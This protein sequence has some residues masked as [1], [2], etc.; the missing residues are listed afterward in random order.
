MP[1]HTVP[2]TGVPPVTGA[3]QVVWRAAGEELPLAVMKTSARRAGEAA[4]D[5]ALARLDRTGSEELAKEFD[6]GRS[7]KS[8]EGEPPDLD[9]L[10]RQV[11]SMIKGM[12]R[13]E[14]E[15]RALRV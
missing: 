1:L 4:P 15:R 8:E 12:L 3:D 5:I 7:Q 6:L 13:V 14:K 9:A 2:P 11:Y 10:A